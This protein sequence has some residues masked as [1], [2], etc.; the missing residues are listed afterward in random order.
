LRGSALSKARKIYSWIIRGCGILLHV[1]DAVYCNKDSEK[2][3]DFVSV[4]KR[5]PEVVE[6]KMRAMS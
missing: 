1:N 3:A 5:S 2:E 6:S 4:K